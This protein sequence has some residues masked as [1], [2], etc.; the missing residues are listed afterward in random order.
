MSIIE[1]TLDK[2]ERSD[3]TIPDPLMPNSLSFQRQHAVSP[4]AKTRNTF[5]L[6]SVILLL[7]AFIVVTQGVELNIS[8]PHQKNQQQTMTDAQKNLDQKIS[9]NIVIPPIPETK[10]TPVELI[11]SDDNRPPLTEPT[12]TIIQ[13]TRS[14]KLIEKP[15]LPLAFILEKII[16]RSTK[17]KIVSK[18]ENQLEQDKVEPNNT[19]QNSLREITNLVTNKIESSSYQ[20]V[21]DTLHQYRNKLSNTWEYY[22]WQSQAYIGMGQLINADRALD[23]GIQK[24]SNKALLWIQKG[25][26]LQEQGNH[27]AAIDVFKKAELMPLKPAS[28][29]LNMGYSAAFMENFSLAKRAYNQYLSMTKSDPEYDSSIREQVIQYVRQIN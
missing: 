15:E 1:R 3:P 2:L 28:L 13:P 23:I 24:N 4:Y 6:L 21:I 16:H 10:E 7:L 26:I 8:I 11:N 5:I 9:S 19:E 18:P 12:D 27:T 17:S 29:Y 14:K 22:Y 20:D 25:L